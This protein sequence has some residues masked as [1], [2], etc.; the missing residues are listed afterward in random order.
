M[1]LLLVGWVVQIFLI[2]HVVRTGR[3]TWWIWV[4]FAAPFIGGLAYFVVELLPGS[5]A[6]RQVAKKGRDLVKSLNPDLDLRRRAQELAICGSVDNKRKLA[7]ECLVRGMPQDAVELY[8]S[9]LAGPHK[10]DPNLLFGLARAHFANGDAAAVERLLNQLEGEHPQFQRE[11]RQLLRA[12]NAT[13]GDDV[14]AALAQ[15]AAVSQNYS[16]LEAAYRYGEYLLQVEQGRAVLQEL[17]AKAKRFNIRH[18]EELY[19]VKQAKRLL[20]QSR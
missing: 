9:T 17:I 16:G 11:E 4:L 12:R 6:E 5:R 13:Y 10:N 1:P 7:E 15:L 3:P 19:W 14:P 18:D 2:I 8:A 20:S